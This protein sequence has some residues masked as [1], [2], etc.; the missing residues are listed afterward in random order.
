V[1]AQPQRLEQPQP[2]APEQQPDDDLQGE[3]PLSE[4]DLRALD[5]LLSYYRSERFGSCTT[6]KTLTFRWKKGLLFPRTTRSEAYED[7]ACGPNDGEDLVT[8]WKI[9]NQL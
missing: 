3:I 2:P 9:L 7:E 4:E 6:R 1:D 8:F 5:T